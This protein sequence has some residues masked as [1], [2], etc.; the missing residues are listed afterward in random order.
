[1]FGKLFQSTFTGSMFGAGP[2]VFAVWSYAIANVQKSRVDL[3]PAMLASILGSD[4]KAVQGAI[5]YL[6]SPDPRSRTKDHEG[7]RLIREGEFQYFMPTHE[8]YR[9]IRNDDERREYNRQSKANERARK[10]GNPLVS[11]RVSMTVNDSQRQSNK[12]AHTEAEPEAEAGGKVSSQS[13]PAPKPP[14]PACSRGP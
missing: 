1:M 9:A 2:V 8:K 3:N 5:D 7:K 13:A 14:Q 10:S 11:T 12:S 6:C 4:A